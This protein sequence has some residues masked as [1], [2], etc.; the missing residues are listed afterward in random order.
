MRFLLINVPIR[1][2]QAPN[3][4][5]TGLGI[6]AAVLEQAGHAVSVLD[7]NAHR[8]PFDVLVS[9][10]VSS[11]PEAVGISGLVSTYK[12]QARLIQALKEKMPEVPIIAG[13]GC[14]TSIPE[15]M[16]AHT[17]ADILVLGEGEHAIAEI[18]RALESG[19]DLQ[20]IQGIVYK[21]DGEVLYTEA[22]PHEKN[23]DV[24]PMP[25]YHLFPVDIY[26]KYP[27][28]NFKE[29]A[30]NLISSRG[31][32][33]ACHF[34]YNLFG[35]KSYRRRGVDSIVEEIRLLKRNYGI[36]TFGFVD[37]NVTIQRGH[38][39]AM[40]EALG[41]EDITWGC[42]GRVDTADD[43]RLS[44]MAAAGCRWLG[45]G[46][47]SGSQRILDAMNKKVKVDQALDAVHR[48]RAHG[49][50][51][52][53]TFIHGY[54]G[55]DID[56]IRDTLRFKLNAEVVCDSFFATPYPGTKLYDL[57]LERG[58]I[59]D[60]NEYALSLNNAYDFTVN[61]TDF[62][63]EELIRLRTVAY[64]E[65][66][67]VSLFKHTPIPLEQEEGFLDVANRFLEGETLLPESK[68]IVLLRVAEYYERK[69]DSATA[70]KTKSCAFRYGASNGML[71]ASAAP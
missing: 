32:P 13:G 57:A 42:H 43:E 38:L 53:T 24:Y 34:C 10:A 4:F 46:I 25:A 66:K 11:S 54:P 63:D 26:L 69:G 64:A 23:L 52:N 35:W 48:T 12:Y 37:D 68:G 62:S 31:C 44:M 14:A 21:K 50:F 45:F 30:M 5:P 29:P 2:D 61:L 7:G 19:D 49:I 59:Q 65:L 1:E 3:N 40:C 8:M 51:A 39:E 55:E 67:I 16:A 71:A 18:A 27:I 22:R 28:W 15:L 33:M 70:F 47:E 58:L 56:S 17:A 20:P 41:K 9:A 6:L 36:R 60:E